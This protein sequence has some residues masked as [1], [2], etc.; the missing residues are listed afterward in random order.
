M[1]LGLGV[2]RTAVASGG[3]YH[4]KD[5]RETP[6]TFSAAF[7]YPERDTQVTYTAMMS[8]S[9]QP[10]ATLFLGTEGSLELSWKVEIYP[11]LNSQKYAKALESG[12]AKPGR[13][14]LSV[15]D[16][17]AGRVRDAN[18]SE[19]WLLGRGSTLTTVGDVEMDTTRL[20][21]ED[22]VQSIRSRRQPRAS[23]AASLPSMIGSHM[24]TIAYREK[25]TVTWDPKERR[26]V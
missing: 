14:I 25:R 21:Q 6:D 9:H 10:Q 19:L 15:N 24:S 12:K 4:W 16:K 8:N 2:P 5:G 13:P 11:D 22:F 7:E 23:L 3:I 18:P 17:A 1:V 26:V 20:H